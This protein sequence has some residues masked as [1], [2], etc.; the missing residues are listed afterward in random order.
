MNKKGSMAAWDV[1]I[2]VVVVIILIISISSLLIIPNLNGGSEEEKITFYDSVIAQNI[3]H[4][5]IIKLDEYNS[6]IIEVARGKNVE[7]KLVIAIMLESNAELDPKYNSNDGKSGLIPISRE[8]A[9]KYGLSITTG[10]CSEDNLEN[11]D[12][13]FNVD[14]NIEA[15]ISHIAELNEQFEAVGEEDRKVFV[16]LAFHNGVESIRADCTLIVEEGFK[17]CDPSIVEGINLAEVIGYE[18]FLG[19]V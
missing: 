13:R 19:I 9:S 3:P 14:K 11:C 12:E 1:T 8:V 17:S 10:G 7:P 2:G 4:D 6:K 15:G 5:K 16:V 18:K